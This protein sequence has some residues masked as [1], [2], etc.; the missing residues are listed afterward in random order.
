MEYNKNYVLLVT[1]LINQ[2]ALLNWTRLRESWLGLLMH[3]QAGSSRAWLLTDGWM[4]TGAT[5]C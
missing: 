2:V 3:I 1:V 4:L 5:A